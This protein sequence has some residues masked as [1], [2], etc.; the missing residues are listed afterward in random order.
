MSIE[1]KL[2]VLGF[3]AFSGTGKTTLLVELISHLQQS[4]YRIG[5]VKQSHHDIEI[6]Q[7]GKDSYKLRKAGATQTI[8]CTPHRQ[9][10]I[11]ESGHIIE[12]E[13]NEVLQSFDHDQLDII[14]VEGFKHTAFSKIELQRKALDKPLLYP[15]DDTIVAVATDEL[16]Q[17]HPIPVLD[18]NDIESIIDFIQTNYLTKE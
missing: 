10:L 14:L 11:K 1:I 3:A 9:V 5:V 17:Q 2:P 15:D 16:N 7:S 4:G 6:D 18:I 8:L 13:L 12:P